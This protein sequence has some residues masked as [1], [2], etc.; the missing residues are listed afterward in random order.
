LA[1]PQAVAFGDLTFRTKDEA[2]RFLKEMLGR[3][4]PGDSVAAKDE[5]VL[6]FALARHPDATEKIG[7]GVAK[8]EV[9]SADYGTKC[10]WARRVDGTL[11][12]FSYA[13]CL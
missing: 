8:F 11:E 2:R 10:F 4:Q 12:R 5:Q 1:R 3:Y 7:V 13:S 9:H 6:R